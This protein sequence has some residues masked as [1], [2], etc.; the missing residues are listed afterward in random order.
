M[1]NCVPLRRISPLSGNILPARIFSNVVLP[2]PKTKMNNEN[3]EDEDEDETCDSISH[4]LVNSGRTF[5][6]SSR[7]SEQGI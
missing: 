5:F 1:F 7:T 3:V 6:T 4:S 2:E